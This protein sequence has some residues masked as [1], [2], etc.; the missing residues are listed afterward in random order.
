MIDA[1]AA[2]F[3][4]ADV[5][6]PFAVDFGP[7][8]ELLSVRPV[9]RNRGHKQTLE[10]D[11]G[12]ISL[13]AQAVLLAERVHAIGGDVRVTEAGLQAMAAEGHEDETD[14]LIREWAEGTR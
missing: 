12:I 14:T 5:T 9:P 6:Q 8:G 4:D 10:V 11:Q 7:N 13:G 3:I 2:E 1:A